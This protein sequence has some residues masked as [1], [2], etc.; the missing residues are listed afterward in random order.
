MN[1]LDR[2]VIDPL[3]DDELTALALAADP[4][5]VADDDAVCMWDVTGTPG[6]RLVPEWY[7]PSPMGGGMQLTGWRRLFARFNVGLIIAAFLV[8]NA[9]GLCNTYGTLHI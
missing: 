6:V 8:I 9:Y 1:V 3:D 5:A 4:D 7:M 2:D